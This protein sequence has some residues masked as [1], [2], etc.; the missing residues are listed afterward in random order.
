MNHM[1]KWQVVALL[2]NHVHA[3]QF[4]QLLGCTQNNNNFS[5][6]PLIMFKPNAPP[7]SLMDSTMSPKRE[8]MEGQGI[9]AHYLVC[10]TL[11]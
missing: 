6:K 2:G 3:M 11:G 5:M 7:N 1:Y 9:K 4:F 10:D 8:T